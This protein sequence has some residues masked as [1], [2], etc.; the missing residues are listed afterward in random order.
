M[1]SDSDEAGGEHSKSVREVK[2]KARRFLQQMVASVSPAF[3]RY[4]ENASSFEMA[5]RQMA[6]R[7]CAGVVIRVFKERRA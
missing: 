3:V 1:A 4:V 7:F 2:Q 5:S 6:T